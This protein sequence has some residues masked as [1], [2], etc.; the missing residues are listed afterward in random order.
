MIGE[1]LKV[2]NLFLIL[3]TDW[4]QV[5][6]NE[7]SDVKFSMNQ[8]LSKIDRLLETHAP[9]IKLNQ[10]ELKFLSKPWVKQDMQNSIK[11]ENNIY[12]KF[13]KCK[14]QKLKEF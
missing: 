8:Y 12:S 11:K 13:V 2:I 3:I 1:N 5:L 7:K 4:E 10:K 14:N 6:C 9:L